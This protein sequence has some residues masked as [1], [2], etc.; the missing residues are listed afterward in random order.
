MTDCQ[1]I[2]RAARG[3]L[4]VFAVS[5]A[6]AA[7]LNPEDHATPDSA[8]LRNGTK[9]TFR[10]Q[11]L[12]DISDYYNDTTSDHSA[13]HC[14][15]LLLS[16]QHLLTTARCVQKTMRAAYTTD[17]GGALMPD[18]YK[19]DAGEFFKHCVFERG[20]QTCNQVENPF[21]TGGK[22]YQ[23]VKI[24][25][26][27]SSPENDLA[28]VSAN[29]YPDATGPSGYATIYMDDFTPTSMP[30][31]QLY[32]WGR[33]SDTTTYPLPVPRTGTMQVRTVTPSR[34]DLNPDQVQACAGDEG[35]AWVVPD[36]PGGSANEVVALESSFT[37][38]PT[39]RCSQSGTLDKA[40][41]LRDK[42]AWIESVIGECQT[43]RDSAGHLVKYCGPTS[44]CEPDNSA[45]GWDGC[46][47]SG[48]SVCNEKVAV[49]YPK[50]F[51]H[52]RNCS[53]N[54]ACN[55]S[56]SRCSTAC[57]PPTV[58]DT[59]NGVP[60]DF[61]VPKWDGCG[62]SGCTACAQLIDG[63]YPK[64]FANH[65]ECTRNTTCSGGSYTRCAS[66]CPPPGD[67]DR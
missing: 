19:F 57:P 39:T 17:M 49:N 5:L 64:Y 14:S 2:Q 63:Q 60:D 9:N 27:T 41:R 38:D 52:H 25:S 44:S 13:V 10:M 33:A 47:G 45:S 22:D 8:E 42:M 6:G 16:P 23:R 31:L 20:K 28:I 58:L 67:E 36:G 3:L 15:G 61:Q 32:G 43:R 65:P 48:C 37:P 4:L 35:G 26:L 53:R 40:V 29:L 59:C 7:C 66:S 24:Y 46:N 50:Y 30:R 62:E 21:V 56:Y 54:T 12:V 18:V 51:D 11:G 34:I 55:G 1:P